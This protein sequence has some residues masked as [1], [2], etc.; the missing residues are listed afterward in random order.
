[1]RRKHLFDEHWNLKDT[2][3]LKCDA[4]ANG[5]K[6]WINGL[7]LKRFSLRHNAHVQRAMTPFFGALKNSLGQV[8]RAVYCMF[9]VKVYR[10][11]LPVFDYEKAILV[12]S[13]DW[14]IDS[15]STQDDPKPF[16]HEQQFFTSLFELADN[17]CE[18]PSVSK[19]VAWLHKLRIALFDYE[20]KLL[21]DEFIVHDERFWFVY[22]Y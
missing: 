19:M 15:G 6:V 2:P 13:E 21:N 8:T 4:G 3:D 18:E 20:D 16:I 22:S 14:D 17:W 9:N 7:V 10:A 11:L 1:M 12:V 5:L